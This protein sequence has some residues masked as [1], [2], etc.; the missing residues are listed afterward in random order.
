M[1]SPV[2]NIKI[3][4]S[5]YKIALF[6]HKFKGLLK[7]VLITI[8]ISFKIEIVYVSLKA[9][10]SCKDYLKK[11]NVVDV[12]AKYLLLETKM[13]GVETEGRR[14]GNV[15]RCAERVSHSAYQ[16][17]LEVFTRGSWRLC[18]PSLPIPFSF[19]PITLF[20]TKVGNFLGRVGSP[21]T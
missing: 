20:N 17:A 4:V 14:L 10:L 15:M 7:K 6:I 19:F 1:I 18:T 13:R 3:C 21:F 9:F 2:K 8:K 11:K 16:E 5:L 12:K